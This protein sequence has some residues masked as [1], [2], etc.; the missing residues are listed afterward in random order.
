MGAPWWGFPSEVFKH[1]ALGCLSNQSPLNCVCSYRDAECWAKL[2]LARGC[3]RAWSLVNC[4]ASLFC[5]RERQARGGWEVQANEKTTLL[6][7]VSP[8]GMLILIYLVCVKLTAFNHAAKAPGF[9]E[10]CARGRLSRVSG[11]TLGSLLPELPEP[12]AAA[13]ASS[14]TLFEW[15]CT[16]CSTSPSLAASGGLCWRCKGAK[17]RSFCKLKVPGLHAPLHARGETS[18]PPPCIT[19]N[20]TKHRWAFLLLS[21]CS[22]WPL[23][24]QSSWKWWSAGRSAKAQFYSVRD[25]QGHAAL[26]LV[27]NVF[28]PPNLLSPIFDTGKPFYTWKAE[29]PR[30]WI[31]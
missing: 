24:V 23:S 14:G 18:L 30:V 9:I 8:K 19:P 28:F 29:S 25:L 15:H 27:F 7:W 1:F 21:L 13:P 10:H 16:S 12:A 11:A 6:L 5:Q 17:G 22:Q 26:H 31:S 2:G 4:N 20:H 3:V